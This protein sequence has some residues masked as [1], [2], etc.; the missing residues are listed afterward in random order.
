MHCLLDSARGIYLP[1]NFVECFDG[2]DW[3]LDPED[4]AILKKGPD[5]EYYWEAWDSV[6]SSAKFIDAIGRV[7][8][9]YLGESG[10]LFA[11][12]IEELGDLEDE[13]FDESY[14]GTER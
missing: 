6:L 14:R 11:A 2:S 7:Y 10:D 13:F 3:G 5:S 12:T 4:V 9:L 1:Q 8:F